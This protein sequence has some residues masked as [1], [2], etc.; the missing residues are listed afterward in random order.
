MADGKLSRWAA[1]AAL[2][3]LSLG[4]GAPAAAETWPTRPIKLINALAAGSAPDILSPMVAEPLSRALGQQVVVENRTGAANILATQAAA[5]AAPDG[6]TLYFGPS[7]ALA[8]NPHTF[9]SLP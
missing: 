2:V 8:V 4:L 6:Y 5:R 7:L 1:S 9:R 3:V